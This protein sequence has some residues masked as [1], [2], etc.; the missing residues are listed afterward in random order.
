[1]GRRNG[2]AQF[3]CLDHALINSHATIQAAR[4]D[5]FESNRRQI[6]F[7]V[8][9]AAAFQLAQAILYGFRIIRHPLNPPLVQKPLLPVRKIEQAP[10]ERCRAE[11]G[12]Q[13]FHAS[14]QIRNPKAEARK[15]SE[16][17][18]PNRLA[19]AHFGLR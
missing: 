19:A 11:I 6:I 9:M 12:D 15:K 17:Q 8:D 16:F 4:H 1:M 3:H 2:V 5:R 14:N 18:N 10:L 13:D 7:I